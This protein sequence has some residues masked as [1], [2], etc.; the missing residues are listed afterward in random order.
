VPVVVLGLVGQVADRL[1]QQEGGSAAIGGGGDPE[2]LHLDADRLG[3]GPAQLGQRAGVGDHL[4]AAEDGADVRAGPRRRAGGPFR[5]DERR[6]LAGLHLAC[7]GEQGERGPMHIRARVEADPVAAARF[8]ADHGVGH[9]HVAVRQARRLR[10]AAGDA[11]QQDGR[12]SKGVDELLGP[13]RGAGV[14]HP[15]QAPGHDAVAAHRRGAVE[16]PQDG[17]VLDRQRGEHDDVGHRWA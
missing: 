4:F 11:D 17:T 16:R 14:A 3:P 6:P 5:A 15:G 1:D 8:V 9:Q 2:A 13:G 7:G 12:G 10:R